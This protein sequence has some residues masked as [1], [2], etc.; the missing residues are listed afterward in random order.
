MITVDA[1]TVE[2]GG[3]TLFKDVSFQI[4]PKDRIALMGKNGAGKS[5]LLKILA[6][7]R[8]ATRGSVPM[9]KDCVVAY[10]PQH[11][12][13]QDK[14]T[15]F[16]ETCQAFAHLHEIQAEIDRIN[17]QL[18]TRTD[19]ESPDYM[20]LIEKLSALSERFYAI[21]STHFDEDVEKTLLGLGFQRSDFNRP[22]SQ[23]SGG[24]RMRIELAKLL[25]KAP[26]VL[27]LDEPTNHLDLRTKD[28][29]K[30]AL[31]DFDGTLI[32]VSHDRDFLD[33]LVS[34][35]YEFRHGRVQEHLGGIYE[36]LESKKMESLHELEKKAKHMK[37]ITTSD[38]HIGNL[39]HGND[40]LPEHKHF[41]KWLLQRIEEQQPDAL[42]IAGDVF[43]N[44]NPSAAAQSAYYEFLADATQASPQMQIII[45]AGNHDSASRLEA[46]RAL[47]T[48]HNVE[49]RGNVRRT[50]NADNDGGK[51]KIDY[52]DLMVPVRTKNGEEIVV[53]TVPYLRSDVVQNAC[54]SEGVNTFLRNLTSMARE[55][56]PD[57]P[58][59]MMAHMYAKGADIA[60]KDASEKIVIGGQEEVNM[61]GWIGHPDYLTCGHIHKRQHIW[62]TDW[63]RYTGSVL[64]M[65]FAEIDY[66]HGVD[67]VTI[68]NTQKPKV[69][70]L[71]YTPQ[72]KLC[73]LPEGDEELTPKKLQ[74]LIREKLPDRTDDKLDDNFVYLV[75]KVKLEKV[76]NDDIKELEAII[77]KKNAVLCKIQ[78]IIPTLDLST[79]ADN[80]H[81]QSID[82]I[83][84]R[85]PLDTLKETFA[86]KHNAEMTE[87]QE[88]ILKQLLE[89]IKGNMN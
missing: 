24:W 60:T 35:V 87:H 38:W 56:Y 52:N 20:L 68:S 6:G 4:N 48:R 13:T 73:I 74:K 62:N 55:T 85:D 43:D 11:L 66:R 16:D 23:F 34:K 46:P 82:D 49:I 67:M 25:L 40:R 29:L 10:L 59:V 79:I 63:A 70:F 78:K 14:R 5:T 39:F 22:T 30:Q 41:L 86:V 69:E 37:L 51:W 18:S 8:T 64:P 31:Q 12:L 65:S 61:Q 76:S 36:F 19:Y 81:I 77:S 89:H 58:I 17:N 53:L 80:H 9:P 50:W 45:T 27:L 2:F 21:D 57:R 1:L 28:V 72:H 83:L 47:L 54:Y 33:G 84:N 7:V 32:V 88:M 42:L 3:T 44:G 15:V 75:L 71:E 26:D